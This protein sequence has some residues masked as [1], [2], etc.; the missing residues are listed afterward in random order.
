MNGDTENLILE[1]LRRM[2][3]DMAIVREDMRDVKTYLSSIEAR[4]AH[5]TVDYGT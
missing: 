1:I 3:P 4:Q 5:S 2:Q